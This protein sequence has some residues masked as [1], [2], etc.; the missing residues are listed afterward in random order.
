M[1][2]LSLLTSLS[3]GMGCSAVF[4]TAL[5]AVLLSAAFLDVLL[6]DGSG[7]LWSTAG[8][9]EQHQLLWQSERT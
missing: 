9:T 6:I 1:E 4:D 2:E 3:R 5:L 8:L 7:G